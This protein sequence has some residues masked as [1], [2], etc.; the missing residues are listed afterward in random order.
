[1]DLTSEPIRKILLSMFWICFL[2][3]SLSWIS[4]P[5]LYYDECIFINAALGNTTGNFI[6]KSMFGIPTMIMAYIGALKAWF[7]AP[8]FA[9]FGVSPATIRVPVVILT[10]VTLI[11]A[12]RLARRLFGVVLATLLVGVLGTDPTL[13]FNTRLDYGPIALM[14]FFKI[15][16]LHL[17]FLLLQSRRARH[18]WLLSVTLLL[19]VYDKLN[20][21][22]FVLAFGIASALFFHKEIRCL[23]AETGRKLFAPFIFFSC[24]FAL[25][26]FYL[27]VPSLS[28]NSGTPGGGSMAE[29]FAFLLSEYT[30]AMNGSSLLPIV[31]SAG[32]VP[33]TLTNYLLLPLCLGLVWL[34]TR[35][36]QTG[37]SSA[38]LQDRYLWFFAAIFLLISLQIIVTKQAGAA[39]HMMMLYP[40]HHLL[41]FSVVYAAQPLVRPCYERY[42]KAGLVVIWVL[43]LCSNLFTDV[44]Y[45]SEFQKKT[46]FTPTW[47]PSI[48]RLSEVLKK[49]NVDSVVCADW[50]FQTP[51]FSL[52]HSKERGKFVEASGTFSSLVPDDIDSLRYAYQRHFAG[53]NVM[54]VLFADNLRVFENVNYNFRRLSEYLNPVRV[55]HGILSSTGLELYQL[56]Y[57]AA[58]P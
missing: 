49:Y 24:I 56:Y 21:V 45:A 8:V 29:R 11:C 20:F 52:A 30:K 41:I 5:G 25:E 44:K 16:S 1:M 37:V 46:G 34:L 23:F 14:L 47:D 33:P 10:F 58:Q 22:W 53:R 19:G 35:R 31:F 38:P 42:A 15:T 18:A 50:G 51:L 17:F 43:I 27:I 7:Y 54:V 13:I 12:F 4:N 55:N 36:I 3:F 28:Y 32:D 2:G 48:Y 39:H 26:V 9:V 57:V 6:H 40:F